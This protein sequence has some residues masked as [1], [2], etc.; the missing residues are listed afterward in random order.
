MRDGADGIEF[1]VRLAGDAVP[2][3]IHD[4]TLKR[5][6]LRKGSIAS[7]SSTELGAIDAGTWF[8]RRYPA[9]ARSE[10]AQARVPTLAQVLKF[11]RT[12][13]AMLYIEMKCAV[14]ESRVL[15]EAVVSLIREHHLESRAVV[16]SF[17][18]EAIRE[19]KSIA[20]NIRT[21][22]LFEP[23]LS[24]PFPA[25]NTIIER[26]LNVAA[27]EIAL[28]CMLANPRAVEAATR[29]GLKTVV[30]TVDHPTW[31]KRAQECGIHAL[32]TNHPLRMCAKR[33]QF[34]TARENSFP[35]ARPV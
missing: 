4:A 29:R 33:R 24:R 5:T 35:D 27:D 23:K 16:E 9:R 3:V 21:A 12:G 31:I 32:I 6:A 26:A 8:N 7:L 34:L 11:F 30:W 22:A 20:Q 19:I 25:K 13:E 10:Y 2:V 18:L 17:A 28:H 1:D 14:S 15:A